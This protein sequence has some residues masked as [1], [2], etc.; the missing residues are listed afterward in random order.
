MERRSIDFHD[1][2]RRP[3]STV[4]DDCIILPSAQSIHEFQS[5]PTMRPR[6]IDEDIFVQQ[7]STEPYSCNRT[8]PLEIPGPVYG[9]PRSKHHGSLD[10]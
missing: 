1:G 7:A 9:S 4:S 6:P 8:A 10:D 5:V 2:S 3:S